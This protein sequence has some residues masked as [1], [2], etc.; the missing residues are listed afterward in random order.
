MA[1]IFI[2]YSS[3]DALIS[4]S[5]YARLVASGHEVWMDREAIKGGEDWLQAIQ[6]NLLWAETLVVLWSANA[7][8]SEWVQDEI[9]FAR[10]RRKHIIPVRIDDT[11]VLM[12]RIR[13]KISSSIAASLST[14]VAA[15]STM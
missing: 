6:D 5:I 11:D 3:R 15:T 9:A 12:I 14:H 4:D 10:S 2:S 13:P 8:Q 7:L 1:K